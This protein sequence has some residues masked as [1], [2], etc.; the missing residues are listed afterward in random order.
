MLTTKVLRLLTLGLLA[1]KDLHEIL[2]VAA[3]GHLHSPIPKEGT[4]SQAQ[5]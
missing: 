2:C 3:E 1:E 4:V 5:S